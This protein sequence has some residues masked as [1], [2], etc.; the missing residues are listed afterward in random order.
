MDELL[1]N[2][3]EAQRIAQAAIRFGLA[4][5]ERNRLKDARNALICE[6]ES[7]FGEHPVK[8]CWRDWQYDGEG[9]G[10]SY[11]PELC[12]NCEK[13]DGLNE[14]YKL[15]SAKSGARQTALIRI[16][17]AVEKKALEKENRR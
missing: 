12:E 15:A 6:N 1:I 10:D 9:G 11:R 14:L 17:R 16:V 8:P 13:R 2:D 3:S 5:I 7:Q 4:R